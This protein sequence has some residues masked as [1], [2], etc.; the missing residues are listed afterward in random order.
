M[1]RLQ[2]NID[3]SATKSLLFSITRVYYSKL[4]TLKIIY[5]IICF[6]YKT[7]RTYYYKCTIYICEYDMNLYTVRNMIRLNIVSPENN[8][9]IL[10]I[11]KFFDSC[12]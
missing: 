8:T 2:A 7:N 1:T 10:K 6:R 3:R 11:A 9:Y 5:K 4:K 12:I